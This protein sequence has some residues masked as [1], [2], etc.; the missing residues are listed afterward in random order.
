MPQRPYLS[1]EQVQ[2]ELG[3]TPGEVDELVRT[4]RLP[5]FC[6]AGHWRVDRSALESLVDA[7]T[8]ET[9]ASVHPATLLPR[10]ARGGDDHHRTPRTSAPTVTVPGSATTPRLTEH[11]Q[12]ILRLVGEGMSNSE[13][14]AA[15]SLEVS[16]VKRHVC[17][18]LQC[19]ALR[20][21]EQLIAHVWRSG[22]MRNA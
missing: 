4:G 15:L 12:R 19:F 18:V 17:R 22:T 11:Q 20:D 10:D 7:L 3:L 13:I 9:M 1:L 21:R 16:T 2:M 14:A 5:A 8:A 6:I